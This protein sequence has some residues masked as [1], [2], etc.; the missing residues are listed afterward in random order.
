[1]RNDLIEKRRSEFRNKY[2]GLLFNSYLNAAL[3]LI[4]LISFLLYSALKIH[5]S[6]WLLIFLPLGFLYSDGAMYLA[7]RF[8]QHKKLKFQRMVFE[9]HTVWH[10]GMFSEEKMH[11]DSIRDTNMVILPFF[12]HGFVL[13]GI[14]LPIALIGEHL[15][16]NIGWVLLFSVAAH[17][18][19]YEIVHTIAHLENPPIFRTLARHHKAHHN[20]KYM[21]RVNFGIATTLFDRLFRTHS[22]SS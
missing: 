16:L 22:T 6:F 1:M 17:S 14:Y 11:I 7:H 9:M 18:L 2:N 3:V 4:I 8:Q 15:Q 13:A 19:W 21:G 12:V 5:L 20:P 10:H